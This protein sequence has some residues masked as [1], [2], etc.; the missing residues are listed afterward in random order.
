MLWADTTDGVMK[1]RNA[2]D[3][4]WIPLWDLTHGIFLSSQC[5]AISGSGG[6]AN[7]PLFVAPF[8]CTIHKIYLASSQTTSGSDGSNHW[9]VAIENATA[10]NTLKATAKN[11][12]DEEFTQ[13]VAWDVAV[14]Q[15]LDIDDGDV[16]Q[17]DL[18][19]VGSPT[20]LTNKQF[21]IVLEYK[22]R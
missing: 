10:A 13:G 8:D 20:S 5:H 12:D 14:D 18:T 1:M 3:T 19:K 11:T 6:V 15:N 16:L 9:E 7:S 22:R 21:L 2:G 17:L 4:A